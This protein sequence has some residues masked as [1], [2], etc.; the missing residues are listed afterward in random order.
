M[1]RE[2]LFRAVG[3]VPEDQ[4]G[5]A[6]TVKKQA[7]PWR[8]FGALA[9]C[10]A[11]LVTAAAAAPW[12]NRGQP[13]WNHILYSFN[14]GA[15]KGETDGGGDA[16]GGDLDGSDYWAEVPVRPGH[17]SHPDYSIDVEIGQMSGPGTDAGMM[18]ASSCVAWKSPEELFAEDT[19]IFR[20]IVRETHYFQVSMGAFNRGEIKI[21]VYCTRALVEVT[22]AIRGNLTEGDVYSLLWLGAKGYMSTSLIGP[23][24]ELDVGGEAIFMPVWTDRDTGWKEGDSYFCYADL[25]E[26]YLSEGTRYVFADTAEGVAFDRGTYAEIAEAESLD[27]IAGYIRGMVEAPEQSRLAANPA[28]MQE[29]APQT[30]PSAG[31]DGGRAAEE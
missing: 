14:P 3:E 13:D 25:A 9:A 12:M 24:E 21:P 17:P 23:L 6:E 11:V 30:P 20:G 7:R 2:E 1:T 15:A 28:E 5:A 18:G 22:D 10:L 19:A 8:R 4:I 27:E 31:P 26:L 29:E 16:G